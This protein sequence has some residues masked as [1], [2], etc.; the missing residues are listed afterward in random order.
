M[1]CI[2]VARGYLM[3]CLRA[4]LCMPRGLVLKWAQLLTAN[5][6]SVHVMVVR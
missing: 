4:I 3:I 6:M 5:A 1:P 2:G